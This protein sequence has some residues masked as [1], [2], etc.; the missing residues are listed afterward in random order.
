MRDYLSYAASEISNVYLGCKDETTEQENFPRST[1]PNK[2]ILI[3]F[4]SQMRPFE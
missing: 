3:D 1:E 2:R 4:L